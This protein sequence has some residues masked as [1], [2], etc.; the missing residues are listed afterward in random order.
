VKLSETS[1]EGSFKEK[2]SKN[3]DNL[4]AMNLIPFVL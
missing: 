3:V 1:G 2:K 4:F